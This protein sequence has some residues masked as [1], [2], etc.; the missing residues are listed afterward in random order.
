[1]E[2]GMA[3][4]P[5][6]DKEDVK[7]RMKG[8]VGTLR[9]EFAGLRTGRA[10]PAILEPVTVEAYGGAMAVNQLGTVSAPEPRLLTV[11]VYDKSLAKAVD[12]A[13]RD[14]GL[15]LNPQL[16]GQ[17]IRIPIPELNEE[18][19]RELAKLA[20][21]YAE[22]ARVAVRNVRRDGMDHLKRLE[23]EHG[24]SEDQHRK[25][26]DELQKLTD[27]SV[28]EIDAALTAKEQEILHV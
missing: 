4:V 23:K 15:G 13:I 25:L 10:N 19:R 16:D 17:L 21:K 5:P 11:Q 6:F 26:S 12:K 20:A 8:A 22:H 28:H 14:A 3:Q 24:I 1:M 18:R 7:R 2:T 9:H 27:E